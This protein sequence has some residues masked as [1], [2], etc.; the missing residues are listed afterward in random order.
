MSGKRRVYPQSEEQQNFSQQPPNQNTQQTQP[1]QT[2]T[3]NPQQT[4]VPS[5]SNSGSYVPPNT[6]YQTPVNTGVPLIPTYPQQAQQSS[7]PS[8]PTPPSP[9]T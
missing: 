1:Y 3:P 7:P 5:Q 2:P 6:Q 4:F 8:Q 9:S